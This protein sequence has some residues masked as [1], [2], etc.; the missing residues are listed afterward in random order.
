MAQKHKTYD[1]V[2]IGGGIAGST[3]GRAMALNGAEVLIVEKEP[4][5]RDRIR[6]EVLLPWGS[7]EAKKLG[8]YDILLQ[9]GAREAPCQV[10]YLEGEPT[11][12]RH[13]PSSTPGQTGLLSFFH[14]DM[15]ETLARAA[16][17]AGVEIWRGAAFKTIDRGKRHKLGILT[18]GT[19]RTI[20]ARLIV[21]ADG[22]DS[23]LA[24]QLGFERKKSPQE[25]FTVGLQLSIDLPLELAMFYFLH[26]R[27]GRGGV[28]IETK[29]G[30]YR[31]YLFHHKDALERRLS[32]ERDYQS[33]VQQFH[34]IGIPSAWL[35][36]ATPHGILA[37][38]DGSFR[39]IDDPV[40][41]NCALVGD[42]ASTTDPV[43]GNGLSRTLRD[44]RLMRDRLLDDS[45]WTSAA[46][47]YA[48]DH[49]DFYHRLRLAE[50]LNATIYF[51]MG[52]AG[53]ARRQRVSTLM[54]EQPELGLDLDGLGP[55]CGYSDEL[56][57]RLL[58]L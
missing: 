54:K 4:H 21:G 15:Q 29:P 2:I 38:F 41:G 10:I 7:L 52:D 3:L 9:S 22:R 39:W 26:C 58:A 18:E 1:L 49:T 53:E 44:V 13:Y 33:A 50:Q 19:V 45:N 36:H 42:A 32:G 57:A 11:P 48:H 37:S 28:L 8:I 23:T 51:T 46:R 17:D 5:Y 27:S 31:A 14:P 24:K 43:W 56:A 25:L 6:G 55:E 16:A 40:D 20:E 30:N 47:A 12:P 35:E 34:E